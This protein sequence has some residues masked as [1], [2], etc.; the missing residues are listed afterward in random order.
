MLAMK[1]ISIL[2]ILICLLSACASHQ[3]PPVK[4]MHYVNPEQYMGKWYEIAAVHVPFEK[5]CV[6]TFSSYTIVKKHPTEFSIGT[7]CRKKSI[8]GKISKGHF[9]AWVDKDDSNSKTQ[10]QFMW[11]FKYSYWIIYVDK[12]YQYTVTGTPDRKYFWILS[13]KP[14]ISQQA[15]DFLLKQATQQGY[16]TQYLDMTPQCLND[17]PIKSVV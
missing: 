12:D 4:T 16:S 6:G 11:P 10:V 5:D 17:K 3:L 15:Y 1:R 14:Q 13:R 7:Q 2:A 9:N 8:H